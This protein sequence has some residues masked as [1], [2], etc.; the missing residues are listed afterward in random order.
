MPEG[1]PVGGSSTHSLTFVTGNDGKRKEVQACLE[2]YVVV[3]NIKLDLTEIQSNSVFEISRNKALRA[4][5]IVKRPVLVEDTALH[6]DALGG[7]PGP[8]IK[9]FLESM[10]PVGLTKLLKGF[11]TR[12]AYALCVFTYC[13]GADM[14]LQFEGR[15]DGTI[16]ESPR[17]KHGFGWDSVFE[18]DE[19]GG[20]TY[21]EMLVNKKNQIS[22]RARA[23]VALKAY[24]CH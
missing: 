5:E 8:Y 9:W 13:A 11:D 23:L 16:V 1:A 18:P 3:E 20:Q 12:R 21:A 17:G 15:C 4:Y 6:F 14:V 10:S 2:G 19:G 7:L 24:F 22:H